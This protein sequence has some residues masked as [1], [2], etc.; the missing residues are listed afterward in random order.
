MNTSLPAILVLDDEPDLLELLSILLT[1]AGYRV[2]TVQTADDMERYFQ[3]G[4]LP[5]LFVLD[6]LLSGS[7]GGELVRH[8]KEA[9]R[10]RDMPILMVS[11]H[12]GAEQEARAGG[13]DA[14]LAKPFDIDEF[15]SLVS[16]LLDRQKAEPIEAK[17]QEMTEPGLLTS[18]EQQE[19]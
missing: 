15:L 13:A 7:H 3:E 18:P 11:A 10:T 2:Q 16:S 14:F 12:P 1:G 17:D 8:L 5:V 4:E 6:L 19:K 9:E